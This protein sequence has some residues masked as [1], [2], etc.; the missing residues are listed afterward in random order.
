MVLSWTPPVADLYLVKAL[1]AM[2][3]RVVPIEGCAVRTVIGNSAEPVSDDNVPV[4]IMPAVVNRM[5][6]EEP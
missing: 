6:L 1:V 5:I 3:M 4:S 2:R